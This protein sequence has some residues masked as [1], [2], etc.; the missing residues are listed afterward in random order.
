LFQSTSL[1]THSPLH[2]SV[3]DLTCRRGGR[4]VFSGISFR[5]EPGEALVLTGRN[6][7]GKSSLLGMLLGRIALDSGSIRLGGNGDRSLAEA[8]H[9]V[10]HKDGLKATLTAQE[11]LEFAR[12][13]LGEPHLSCGAALESVGLGHAAAIPVGYLSAGQKRRVALARLLVARRPLWLLDEPT[14]ALDAA[15]Q[16]LLTGLMQ[17]HLNEGGLIIAATHAPLGL[18][19]SRELRLDAPS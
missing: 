19:S 11:N 18:A 2:L 15:A 6:G 9:H 4:L 16:D 12:T 3:T 17:V 14:A 8:S 10:G 13:M 7:A 5:L 1:L